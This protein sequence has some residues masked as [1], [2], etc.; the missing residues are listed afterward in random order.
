MTYSLPDDYEVQAYRRHNRNRLD[1]QRQ[2]ALQMGRELLQEILNDADYIFNC[3]SNG[4]MGERDI[5]ALH[6]NI[7]DA[8]YELYEA[9]LAA[10]YLRNLIRDLSL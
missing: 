1:R 4:E 5:E 6:N 2:Q 7:C 9:N 10:E 8:G 3:Y